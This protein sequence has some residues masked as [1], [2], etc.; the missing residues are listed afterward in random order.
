MIFQ[1]SNPQPVGATDLLQDISLPCFAV[2]SPEKLLLTGWIEKYT[3]IYDDPQV[4]M[5][6]L[7]S[8]TCQGKSSY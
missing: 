7:G 1:H 3:Y 4:V 6:T 2:A 5:I 8:L